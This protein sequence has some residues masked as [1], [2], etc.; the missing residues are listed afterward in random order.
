MC[1]KKGRFVRH[2]DQ[3]K[4]YSI[5]LCCI[6]NNCSLWFK[7]MFSLYKVIDI[8]FFEDVNEMLESILKI[9]DRDA[10]VVIWASM[11]PREL[12]G[13][14][15]RLEKEKVKNY[16]YVT[17]SDYI[18]IVEQ[19]Y[20]SYLERK[21]IDVHNE[22]VQI[23][24]LKMINGF[25]YPEYAVEVGDFV[26]PCMFNDTS[27]VEDGPYEFDKVRLSKDDVVFD[28]GAH[29]GSFSMYS[30]IKGCEVY[31]FEPVP[32]TFKRL[33]HNMELYSTDKIHLINRGVWNC[34]SNVPFYISED[35]A[36]DS[37]ILPKKGI[38]KT[39]NV[40]SI[41]EFVKE[42]G[43]ERVDF[44]KADVEGAEKLMIEGMRETIRKFHPKLSLSA[45]HEADD[46][47]ILEELIL[48]IDNKYK[49]HHEWKKVYAHV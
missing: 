11:T 33:Q 31:A 15:R 36:T 45:Y 6:S 25:K 1:G 30:I 39:L 10:I 7:K 44:V 4:D 47:K 5:I 20:K 3:L 17:V 35:S 34:N 29:N 32:E 13:V 26:L 12:V 42:N 40:I 23:G 19:Y 22:I 48:S 21:N 27:M 8:F 14:L 28:C 9:N 49:I 2:F 24:D 41:D 46:P 18:E 16:H 37:A 38:V 43:I